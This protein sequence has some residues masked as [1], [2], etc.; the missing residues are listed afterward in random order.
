M[1]KHYMTLQLKTADQTLCQKN[2]SST[3]HQERPRGTLTQKPN[4]VWIRAQHSFWV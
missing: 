1:K 2:P 4:Q 3:L